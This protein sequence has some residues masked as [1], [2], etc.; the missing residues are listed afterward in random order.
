M[1]TLWNGTLVQHIHCWVGDPLSL[2]FSL[3]I[4]WSTLHF[5]REHFVG[6]AELVD[7]IDS[8][9][10]NSV[11]GGGVW[12]PP[13]AIFTCISQATETCQVMLCICEE[14]SVTKHMARHYM[15]VWSFVCKKKLNIIVIPT[16]LK[17]ECTC[18]PKTHIGL[19]QSRRWY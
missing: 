11:W 18:R 14:R 15:L 3:L 17:V 7:V 4:N 8:S 10:S 19:I 12:C 16:C 2:L 1:V 5:C 6:L 13:Y 9:E